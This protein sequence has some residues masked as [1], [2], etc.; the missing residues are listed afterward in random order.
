MHTTVKM[1][2]SRSV[3]YFCITLY[4]LLQRAEK[5]LCVF[6]QRVVDMSSGVNQVNAG[7]TGFSVTAI[8]I[9][10]TAVMNATAVSQRI[11][12]RTV[13]TNIQN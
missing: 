13:A 8:V 7:P 2:P 6:M 9:A 12:Y 10:V 3:H 11:T 4:A 5:L 1:R